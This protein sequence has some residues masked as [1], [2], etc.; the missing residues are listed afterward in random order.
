V[1]LEQIFEDCLGTLIWIKEHAH[2]YKGDPDRLAVTGDSAGGHLAAMIVTQAENPFF[3][4][5][6]QGH[7]SADR[8]VAAAAPSYGVFDFSDRLA[9]GVLK[10]YLGESYRDNPERRDRL[11]PIKQVRPGLPPQLVIVGNQDPLY[12]QNRAY[13]KALEE[14]GAPVELWVFK[15]QAHAFLNNFWEDKGT[16]G[17]DRIVEFL[18]GHLK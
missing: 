12:Y 1:E 14:V 13:V 8:R 10:Q 9:R 2:K 18:D 11:S 17:Y 15:G 6:Y 16:R 5:T 4:P 7:G 3:T